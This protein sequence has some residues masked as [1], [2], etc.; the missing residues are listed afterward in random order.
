MSKKN[1]SPSLNRVVKEG[2]PRKVAPSVF[3]GKRYRL[4]SPFGFPGSV[5]SVHSSFPVQQYMRKGLHFLL[6]LMRPQGLERLG[7][8]AQAH[9]AGSDGVDLNLV[10]AHALPSALGCSMPSTMSNMVGG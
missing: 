6:S 7:H 3:N 10:S 9:T 2:C 8:L 5:L 1:L 4:L